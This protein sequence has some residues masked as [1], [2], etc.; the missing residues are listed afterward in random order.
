LLEQQLQPGRGPIL[1]IAAR[2]HSPTLA[3][4]LLQRGLDLLVIEA[5]RAEKAAS[6]DPAIAD[7]LA[8]AAFDGILFYSRRTAE[9][10]RAIADPGRTKV[11][12]LFAL[13]PRVAEGLGDYDAHVHIA[14]KPDEQSLLAL[15]PPP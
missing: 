7:K 10:F 15:I 14:T 11:S 8:A 4:G 12:D 9:A 6:L 2:D 1:Y 13:S 5:Y 3:T